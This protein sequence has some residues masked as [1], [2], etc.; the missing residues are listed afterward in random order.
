MRTDGF[1]IDEVVECIR[2]IAPD[3]LHHIVEVAFHANI[4]IDT[5]LLVQGGSIATYATG[6]P[7]PPIPFW[8]LIFKNIQSTTTRKAGGLMKAPRR[9]LHRAEG[10]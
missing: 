10:G 4:V 7:S 3:G 5:E 9:G 1:A 6:H 2:T 8:P